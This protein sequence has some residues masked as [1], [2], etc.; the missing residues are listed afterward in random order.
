[1]GFIDELKKLFLSSEDK[2]PNNHLRNIIIMGMIGTL[3]LLFGNVFF[4]NNPPSP[5]V[6]KSANVD[7]QNLVFEEKYENELAVKLEEIISLIEGVGKVKVQVYVENS[8][9]YE[10][11]FNQNTTNKITSENDQNGGERRIEEDTKK[12]D[13]V[14]LRDSSGNEKPVI[15]RKKIPTI[16]GILIVAQGAENSQTKSN[17]FRAVSSFLNLPLYRIS[18][19]PYEG[20]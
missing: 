5:P 20:R 9:E 7:R 10:Y 6:T 17:I 13:M 18:V 12:N 16:T 8:I 1:M 2:S 19:L 4:N 3:L 11:E 15:K 14:I